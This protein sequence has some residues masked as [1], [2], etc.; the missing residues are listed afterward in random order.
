[1]SGF[2]N[3]ADLD[4]KKVATLAPNAALKAKQDK[5]ITLEAFDSSY[6]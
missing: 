3:N 1:M 5:I 4:K 6:F 2:I